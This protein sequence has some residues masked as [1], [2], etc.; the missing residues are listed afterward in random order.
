MKKSIT[1]KKGIKIIK[2]GKRMAISQNGVEIYRK[3]KPISSKMIKLGFVYLV[4]DCSGSMEEGNKLDQARKG[5][6]RFAKK[7]K[8]KGYS[9]GLIQFHSYATHLCEPVSRISILDQY[10][11][12]IKIGD[13]THMVEGINL[14][15][16]K[17]KSKEGAR[18]MVVATDGMPNGPGDPGASIKAGERA[19]REGINIITIGTDDADREFLKKLASRIELGVK[20]SRKQFQKAFTSSANMLSQLGEG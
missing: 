3:G 5:A 6:F 14:A 12:N 9:V 2:Q 4:I 19:K 18:A 16:Q 17:L 7:A 8:V 11:K 13:A 1:S 10:L 20:V 15:Y